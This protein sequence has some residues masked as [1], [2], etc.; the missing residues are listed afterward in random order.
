MRA[1]LVKHDN[2]LQV[3]TGSCRFCQDEW[4]DIVRL[5]SDEHPLMSLPPKHPQGLYGFPP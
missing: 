1:Q 3:S 2:E 4:T 5:A